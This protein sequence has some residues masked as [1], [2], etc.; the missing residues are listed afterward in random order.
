MPLHTHT[1]STT[2]DLTP[3]AVLKRHQVPL[4]IREKTKVLVH[5][6]GQYI[7]AA[8]WELEDSF[9]RRHPHA[10]LQDNILSGPG[11]NVTSG[12]LN[13]SVGNEIGLQA[14]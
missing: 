7:E 11:S 9:F 10:D 6:K 14:T 2:T 13:E 3:V 4:D 1:T 5:W 8:M 12:G